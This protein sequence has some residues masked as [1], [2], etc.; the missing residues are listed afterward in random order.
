M[1][2][3]GTI[4]VWI[5]KKIEFQIERNQILVVLFFRKVWGRKSCRVVVSD[6]QVPKG[7]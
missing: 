1:V 3:V 6:V 7:L 4:F 2:V 5:M